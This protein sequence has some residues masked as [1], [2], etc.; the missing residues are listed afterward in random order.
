MVFYNGMPY[1]RHYTV[2]KDGVEY[3]AY[4]GD[5]KKYEVKSTDKVA[6]SVTND[7][8]LQK[9]FLYGNREVNMRGLVLRGC[10]QITDSS[11]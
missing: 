10:P 11:S 3:R 1:T 4:C 5:H 6:F 2:H 8:L 7:R 9:A